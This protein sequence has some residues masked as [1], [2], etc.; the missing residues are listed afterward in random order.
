MAAGCYTHRSVGSA[1]HVHLFVIHNRPPRNDL[2]QK[3]NVTLLTLT[4]LTTTVMAV[5]GNNITLSMGMVGALSIVRFRTAIKDSRDTAYIFWTI[6][7]GICCGVGDFFVAATGSTAAFLIMLLFGSIRSDSRMLLLIRG[8]R[9]A[10]PAIEA[11]VFKSFSRKATLRAKN[12]T[13]SQVEFIYELSSRTFEKNRNAKSD[14]SDTA[15]KIGGIDYVN[16]V[17]QSDEVSA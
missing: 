11:L 15:F 6:I 10:E 14:F 13:D 9:S 4:V 17:M 8:A 5:I 2:Q 3:F 12:S 1:W 16:F 7:V